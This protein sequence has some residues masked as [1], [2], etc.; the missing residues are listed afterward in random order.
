MITPL[1]SI[2]IPIY[3][4]EKY[5]KKCVDSVLNQTYRNL[6][7][8]LV[9]D[10]SPDSCPLICDEYACLDNRVKVIHK[11]NGGLSDARNAGI[12]I[13]TGEAISFVDSDDW[14]ESDMFEKMYMR[15]CR[16]NSDI[17]SCGIKW[18][19]DNG[20]T[21]NN[22]TVSE[23]CVLEK[24]DAM[25]ELLIDGKLKQISC[26]KLYRTELVKK[27]PFEKGK[28]H[29]DV[30]WSYQIIGLAE[31]V[32]VMTESFYNYFQRSNSI[33][34][35]SYSEKRLDALD[36]MKLRCEYI[37]KYFPQL[38]NQALYVYIGNCMYHIQIA[39]KSKADRAIVQ[40]IKNRIHC[41]KNGDIFENVTGK[42]KMWLKMFVSMPVITCRIR[43]LLKIGL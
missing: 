24:E 43:N 41:Y 11:E 40:N 28:Y 18:V 39:M 22:V 7:I 16:D 35:E 26:G 5:I 27:I 19:Y 32:S 33:M 31:K 2:V 36:A 8:I 10:G 4:V 17:V 29:E 3:N 30:F 13:A 34:G 6:E 21:V 25:K 1:I 20:A 42:Q 14:I 15:L 23:N 9:D 37:Q 12:K 38:Y